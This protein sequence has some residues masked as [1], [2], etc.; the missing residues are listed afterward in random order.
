MS[1]FLPEFKDHDTVT[2]CI[3][4]DFSD[5]SAISVTHYIKRGDELCKRYYIKQYMDT[6]KK[7][8]R[9][10]TPAKLILE[11]IPKD[12]YPDY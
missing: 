8:K 11:H 9:P 12:Y 7:D 2:F 10:E 1:F 5:V 4:S 6:N 3:R